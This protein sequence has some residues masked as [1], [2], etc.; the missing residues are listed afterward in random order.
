MST[1]IK[2]HK[3]LKIHN[4][5]NNSCAYKNNIDARKRIISSFKLPLRENLIEIERLIILANRHYQ[6]MND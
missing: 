4:F 6:K 1:R 3:I 5:S 2:N